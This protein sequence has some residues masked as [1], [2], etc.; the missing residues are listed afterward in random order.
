MAALLEESARG[1]PLPLHPI[2]LF[3]Y[4]ALGIPSNKI[5]FSSIADFHLELVML[6]VK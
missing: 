4:M 2:F 3:N 1:T 6:I 5:A